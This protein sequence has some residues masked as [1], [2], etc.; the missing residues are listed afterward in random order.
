[1]AYAVLLRKI[2]TDGSRP[3]H[4]FRSFSG[5]GDT[6]IRRAQ[7]IARPPDPSQWELIEIADLAEYDTIDVLVFGEGRRQRALIDAADKVVYDSAVSKLEAQQK[8][9][10]MTDDEWTQ[11]NARVFERF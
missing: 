8:S 3:E 6:S 7:L 2:G 9:A 4:W 1:M 5:S 10:G 11:L